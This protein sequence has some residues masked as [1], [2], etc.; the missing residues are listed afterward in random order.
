MFPLEIERAQSIAGPQPG[1]PHSQRLQAGCFTL[2]RHARRVMVDDHVLTLTT[3]E[4]D[5]LALLV[6]RAGRIVRRDEMFRIVFGRDS[7][8]FD[9]ALDVHLSHVRAK[10]GARRSLIV[11]VR[12]VGHLLRPA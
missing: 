2:E 5:M 6:E 1:S 8:V 9:R 3:I 10:L 11:T 12:G 7:S 4:Y